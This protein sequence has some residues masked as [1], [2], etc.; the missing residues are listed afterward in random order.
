MAVD[1]S[2]YGHMPN[3]E[4]VKLFTIRN[5]NGLE[6]QLTNFGAILVALKT[7]DRTGNIADITLGFDTLQGWIDDA[8][9]QGATVG[10]YGNRIALGRFELDGRRYE[11]ATNDGENHLHGGI[12]G[13]HKVVWQWET[14]DNAVTFRYVS[15]DGEEGYPGTL[16]TT[17]VYEL[18]D[19]DELHIR[20]DAECDQATVINLVNHTYWNL[21]AAPPQTILDHELML[22]ADAYLPVDD[23]SIPIGEQQAVAGTPMDF[24]TPTPIG[25]RID[26]TGGYDHNWIIR[27][28]RG[29]VRRAAVVYDPASGRQMELLTDQPGVQFY[30]GLFLDGSF[31]GK[32]NVAYPKNGGFCLETQCFP[33]SP[34]QPA[35]PSPVLRPGENYRHVMIHRFTTR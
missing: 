6:A 24:T 2:S 28:E 18:T 7:P 4:D 30:A 3:G 13:F 8:S 19:S 21:S 29:N 5:R 9:Y 27:G 22:D 20:F 26:T 17:V 12:H 16:T 23:G 15:V 33:D 11:L 31:L 10:R 14:G 34:N 35:F 1:V 32:G 25:A